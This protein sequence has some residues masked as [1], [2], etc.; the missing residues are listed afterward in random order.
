[1]LALYLILLVGLAA[2]YAGRPLSTIVGGFALGGCWLAICLTG[3]ITYDRLRRS[4][5]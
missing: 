5:R 1:M 4:T 3:P 2:L